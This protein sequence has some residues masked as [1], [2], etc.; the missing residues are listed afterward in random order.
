MEKKIPVIGAVI[1]II[2]LIVALV[3]LYQPNSAPREVLLTDVDN[4]NEI[5][6]KK[7]QS[8][9]ISLDS[10]PTTGYTWELVEQPDGQILQ[11]VGEELEFKPE[12][13]RI[14]AGG[15]QTIRF[16]VV[17]VGQTALKIVYHRPWE[18]DVAP[19]RIYYIHVLAR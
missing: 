3:M 16:D 13:D 2:V 12:A 15:T 10:N 1:F 5:E 18:T 8:L 4:G 19:E 7:G 17:G 11:Q 9:V 14:G 6:V